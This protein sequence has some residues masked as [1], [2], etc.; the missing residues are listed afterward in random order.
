MNRM[1][2]GVLHIRDRTESTATELDNCVW[3]EPPI[4]ILRHMATNLCTE[5]SKI[6]SRTVTNCGSER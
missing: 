5:S 4:E 2:C 3:N 1:V 6:K